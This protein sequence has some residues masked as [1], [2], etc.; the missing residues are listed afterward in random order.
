[1][2]PAATP[3]EHTMPT[4]F[5]TA[6]NDIIDQR[7]QPFGWT[8]DALAGDDLVFGSKFAD[9][10][11]GREG[12]DRLEGLDGDDTIWGGEGRDTVFGGAGDD[13]IQGD[14][15]TQTRWGYYPNQLGDAD[16][17][18]G[19]A[20]NDRIDG[21]GGDDLI[22]GE[23]GDDLI[24][25]GNGN[26]T[27]LGGEGADRILAG[28]GRDDVQGGAGD[29]RIEGFE[30]ADRLAGGA[31]ADRFEYSAEDFYTAVVSII[32][33]PTMVDRFE[34][35]TIADFAGAAGDRIDL[36]ALYFTASNF[37]GT[38]AD[39]VAQGYLYWVA[40]GTGTT[41]Y[42][43]VNGGAHTAMDTLLGDHF[44]LAHLENV[45]PNQV[46]DAHFTV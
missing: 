33:V 36:F 15:G 24:L 40:S 11:F 6:F 42:V 22:L 20:G 14:A 13:V 35:D 8:I 18:Y 41:V 34:M 5:G 17:L 28:H 25:G 2:L 46:T 12:A 38:A 31:G 23:A 30:G 26:D 4:R 29:D 43:D 37:S 9:T 19:G 39:A 44:A 32:G 7:N 45:A 1:M 27:L 10:I 21:Q 3:M 16:R